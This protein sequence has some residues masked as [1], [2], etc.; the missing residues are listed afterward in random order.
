MSPELAG[1][2]ILAQSLIATPGG[3][4]AFV[5]SGGLATLVCTP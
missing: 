1:Q 5:L 4:N 3:S 2:T